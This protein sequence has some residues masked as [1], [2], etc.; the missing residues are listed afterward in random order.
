MDPLDD[1]VVVEQRVEFAQRRVEVSDQ[2]RDQCKE[3]D[4]PI[5]IDKH[6]AEAFRCVTMGA[7]TS[8]SYRHGLASFRTANEYYFVS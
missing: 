4:G 1:D 2:F 8:P 5:A 6:L 7:N 3:V